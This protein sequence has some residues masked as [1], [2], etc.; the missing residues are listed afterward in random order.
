MSVCGCGECFECQELTKRI[1]DN[2]TP[3]Q[4]SFD[5]DKMMNLEPVA[6]QK[7]EEPVLV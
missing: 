7:A 3:E 1:E 5:R 6:T 4:K 2:L